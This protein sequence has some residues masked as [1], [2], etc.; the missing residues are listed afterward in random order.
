MKSASDK[1]VKHTAM[2]E[3]IYNIQIRV[4]VCKEGSEYVARALEM[5]LL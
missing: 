5:D 1:P 2:A 3:T 4:L